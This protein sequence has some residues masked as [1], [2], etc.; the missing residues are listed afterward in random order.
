MPHGAPD[1]SPVGST[2]TSE[3]AACPLLQLAMQTYLPS[4]NHHWQNHAGGNKPRRTDCL[5]Q[6]LW[7]LQTCM[8]NVWNIEPRKK[9]GALCMHSV[10]AVLHVRKIVHKRLLT[11]AILSDVACHQNA[12]RSA[13]GLYYVSPTYKHTYQTHKRQTRWCRCL[14]WLLISQCANLISQVKYQAF[15]V[16][17]WTA[18]ISKKIFPCLL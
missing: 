11:V 5:I 14:M 2:I 12:A 6:R 7:A 15:S 16:W 18:S 10:S 1:Q 9:R 13:A 4:Q 8:G 17:Q 3:S